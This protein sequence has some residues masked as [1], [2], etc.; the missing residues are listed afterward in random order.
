MNAP[1]NEQS[2]SLDLLILD[3]E[4]DS[5]GFVTV[6]SRQLSV[7]SPADRCHC[8]K[9]LCLFSSVLFFAGDSQ[10]SFPR[11]SRFVHLCQIAIQFRN[12]SE[13]PELTGTIT[14]T[15]PSLKC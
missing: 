1:A 10:G 15:L 7:I 6:F 2:S 9:R 3:C 5:M 8:Q 4:P 14:R 13:C 11:D 12:L